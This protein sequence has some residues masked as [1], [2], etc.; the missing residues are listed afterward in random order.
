MADRVESI[1][2]VVRETRAL[3]E[4]AGRADL[5]ERL[6]RTYDR[7]RDPNVRVVV[8]GEFK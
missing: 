2:R 6:D 4:A 7:L 8:V 1:A 3:A 5:A